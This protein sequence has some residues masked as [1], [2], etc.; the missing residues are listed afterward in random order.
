MTT[1]TLSFL[2][3]FFNL[4]II[5]LIDHLFIFFVSLHGLYYINE[6]INDAELFEFL[7]SFDWD[8]LVIVCLTWISA[9][10]STGFC[11]GGRGDL[12]YLVSQ[13]NEYRQ[14]LE[15]SV[16]NLGGKG[17][18]NNEGMNQKWIAKRFSACMQLLS[19]FSKP[20]THCFFG[21]RKKKN[22]LKY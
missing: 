9:P 21:F 2:S 12:R 16:Q 3:I 17:Y 15:K 14:T 5:H 20:S 13:E 4:I 18:G 6:T 10:E 19:L 22:R 1:L 7:F 8:R 11:L